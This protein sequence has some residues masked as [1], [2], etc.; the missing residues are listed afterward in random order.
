MDADR[1][2][3]PWLTGLLAELAREAGLTIDV[4]PEWGYAGRVTAPDG[5]AT[6][7]VGTTLDINPAG[8]S[9]LV[10]D[11]A[12]AAR[13]ISRLG[14]PVPK[15]EP[16]FSDPW[17]RFVESE[18]DVEWACDYAASIGFPVV[19]KPNS[20]SA[21]AGVAKARDAGELR[22]AAAAVF[23]L[24]QDRV[25]VVQEFVEGDDYRVLLFD[26]DLI[27]AYRRSRPA[28]IGDG[29]RTAADLLRGSAVRG[30]DAAQRAERTLRRAGIELDKPIA[31]GRR[32]ELLDSANL[33]SGGTSEDVT[34]E[35]APEFAAQLA[36]L[37]AAL[38]LRLCGI[39]LI[40]PGP[41]DRIPE[42]YWILEINAAP[43]VT[44]YAAIG[45]RQRQTAI[46]LYKRIV[47]ALIGTDL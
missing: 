20:R 4:E 46:A 5:R 44:G 24:A 21:G 11:K 45:E 12:F 10:A 43:Q 30:V 17:S 3:A 31:Q 32:V 15:G 40:V 22:E 35:L 14:F 42:P 19:V 23:S 38:N 13:F 47:A 18:R 33:S 1:L 41:I 8:A 2:P 29:R 36:R 37:P 16:F 28:V 25:A 6:C 26:G 39:D 34:G 9:A 7:F 27:A